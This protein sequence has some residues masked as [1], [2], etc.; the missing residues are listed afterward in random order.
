MDVFPV[1]LVVSGHTPQEYELVRLWLGGKLAKSPL[2]V[3]ELLVRFVG[4]SVVTT[5]GTVGACVGAD[6]GLIVGCSVGAEVS[7]SGSPQKLKILPRF[8]PP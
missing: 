5:G 8:P 1:T 6:D 2:K 7:G 3:A 4:L